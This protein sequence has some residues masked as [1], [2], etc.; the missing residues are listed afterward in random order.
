MAGRIVLRG[1]KSLSKDAALRSE[2]RCAAGKAG[3]GHHHC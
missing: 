2:E 3:Q 1:E